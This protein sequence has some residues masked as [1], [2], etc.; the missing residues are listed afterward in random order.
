M[1]PKRNAL[2]VILLRVLFFVTIICKYTTFFEIG[3]T[4]PNFK[5]I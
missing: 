3:K 1:Q 2:V 4:K 5:Y